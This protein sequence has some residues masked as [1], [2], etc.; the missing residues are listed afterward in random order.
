MDNFESLEGQWGI[1]Q[2]ADDEG[3]LVS[4]VNGTSPFL[5][6]RDTGTEASTMSGHTGCNSISGSVEVGGDGAFA[7]DTFATTLM[8]CEGDVGEQEQRIVAAL[9]NADT[10]AIKGDTATLS[11]Q[12]S[13]VLVL[14]RIDTTLEG[15]FWVV[16]GINNQTGGVQSVVT[17]TE[18]TL[19]FDAV[20]NLTGTTGC[21]NLMGTYAVDGPTIEI[22]PVATTRKLCS[23]PAGVMEQEQNMIA[24]L[25]RSATYVIHGFTLNLRDTDGST[26]L[27]AHRGAE[28]TP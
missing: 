1:E 6:F 20:G 24:A 8:A 7:A 19:W 15:S 21:N 16:T 13:A 25:N 22:G 9:T 17:G 10:W 4:A 3:G 23:A 12:G 14:H 11:S 18:P 2:V 26:M 27:N 5:A 28:P